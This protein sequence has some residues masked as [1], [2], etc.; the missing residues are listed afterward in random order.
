MCDQNENARGQ[1]IQKKNHINQELKNKIPEFKN[2]L[3][4]S[5]TD[6]IKQKKASENLNTVHF[7]LSI[8]GSK[9]NVKK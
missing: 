6:F 9:N 1:K 2:T 3:Q 4:M 8:Q 7:H 5:T